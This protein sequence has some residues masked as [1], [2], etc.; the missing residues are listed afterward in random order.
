[1]TSEGSSSDFVQPA[2]PKLDGHYD[3]WA[4]LMENFMRSKNFGN[5]LK[6]AYL[7]KEKEQF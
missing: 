7:K 2:I 3:H 4:M 6:M 5:L 1:M